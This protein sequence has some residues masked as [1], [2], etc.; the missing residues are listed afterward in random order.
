M[1]SD[2]YYRHLDLRDVL[3]RMAK[4]TK[5]LDKAGDNE[6]ASFAREITKMLEQLH[7][8]VEAQMGE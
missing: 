5:D 2:L 4:V 8:R 1:R 7:E 3:Q 6:G